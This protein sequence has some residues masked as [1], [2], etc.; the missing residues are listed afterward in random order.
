MKRLTNIF[1][2]SFLFILCISCKNTKN[3][4]GLSTRIEPQLDSVIVESLDSIITKVGIKMERH[5]GVFEVPCNVNGVPLKFIFDTGASNVCLSLTEAAFLYKNGY[6]DD[7]DFVGE[8][9]SQIAD[10]SVIENMEIILRSIVIEGIEINNVR[11]TVI[12]SETAPLLLG[13][14]ALQQFGRIV[15]VGDSLYISQRVPSPTANPKV[16]NQVGPSV[17]FQGSR[18]SRKRFGRQKSSSVEALLEKAIEAKDNNMPEL[19][20][21]YCKEAQ[22]INRKDWRVLALLGEYEGYGT[23][24]FEGFKRLNTNKESFTIGNLSVSW[25]EIVSKLAARYLS[26]NLHSVLHAITTSQELLLYNPRNTSAL[27]TLSLAYAIKG[28]YDQALLWENK[29]M[30]LSKKEGY[31]CLGY[32]SSCQGRDDE[33]INAYEKCLEF[34][35]NYTAALYNLALQYYSIAQAWAPVMKNIPEVTKTFFDKFG[36]ATRLF[37]KAARLGDK[38]AQ[39]WLKDHNINW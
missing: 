39:N 19:A 9:Y 37:T 38:K 6:L 13:Q 29:L 32:I 16:A 1:I 4:G 17:I 25:E 22:D 23:D 28:D 5:G 26:D 31:F 36:E 18:L 2:V 20:V 21:Q 30:R 35:P 10:G 8:S 34:D 27:R 14:T 15:F 3:E 24:K 7:T 12:R 11:A 33:T